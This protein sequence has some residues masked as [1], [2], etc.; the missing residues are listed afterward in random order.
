MLEG[1]APP[2]RP[3][4]AEKMKRGPRMVPWQG[5]SLIPADDLAEVPADATLR[6]RLCVSWDGEIVPF[7]RKLFDLSAL[8]IAHVQKRWGPATYVAQLYDVDPQAQGS[9][10]R[11]KPLAQRTYEIR[12]RGEFDIGDESWPINIS[13]AEV[14]LTMKDEFERRCLLRD[15]VEEGSPQA[16][17]AATQVT[18]SAAYAPPAHVVQNAQA[19][20]APQ[21]PQVAPGQFAFQPTPPPPAGVGSFL[22]GKS[23][24][25]LIMLATGVMKLFREINSDGG[26]GAAEAERIR[27]EY[28]MRR[29]EATAAHEARMEELRF[30]HQQM[31]AASAPRPVE[32][33]IDPEA[34]RAKVQAEFMQRE[35][36]A[37][38]AEMRAAKAAPPVRPMSVMEEVEKIT[39]TA[40]ALGYKRG[41]HAPELP[42]PTIS[43]QI[44]DVLST[45]GGKMI[46]GM[47]I[48]KALDVPVPPDAPEPPP[49]TSLPEGDH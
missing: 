46:A 17:Q 13:A 35:L 29:Q 20:Q 18:S 49:T 33:P 41:G 10:M 12:A 21:A 31:L 42:P 16:A 24:E 37:M 36:D 22:A 6:V 7:D 14:P 45:P 48:S 23:P 25:E 43:E 2:E 34:I 47:L 8:T 9:G 1:G 38:R 27:G 19:P 3:Q 44:G 15:G 39:K 40:E 5:C 28:E 30:Q 32:N 26:K 11:G 4:P